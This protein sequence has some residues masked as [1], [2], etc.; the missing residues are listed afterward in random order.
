MPSADEYAI[1][2]RDIEAIKRYIKVITRQLVKHAKVLEDIIK[3]KRFIIKAGIIMM[4]ASHVG[5]DVVTP[6]I[7]DA[8]KRMLIK[9]VQANEKFTH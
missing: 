7:K 3:L 2:K 4:L 6:L 5:G 1:L 8:F 9:E